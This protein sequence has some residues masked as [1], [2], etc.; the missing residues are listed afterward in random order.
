MLPR[1]DVHQVSIATPGVRTTGSPTM[2]SWEEI[3]R[4]LVLIRQAF[5]D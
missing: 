1:L 4:V 5:Y 3:N 2:P